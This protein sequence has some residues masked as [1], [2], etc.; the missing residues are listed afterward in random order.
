MR[1]AY[2]TLNITLYHVYI[3]NTKQDDKYETYVLLSIFEG[4]SRHDVH[5]K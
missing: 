3:N 2:C 5:V 1:K 4:I